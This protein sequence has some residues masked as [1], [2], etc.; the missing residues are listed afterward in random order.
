VFTEHF[1]TG[2]DA[3]LVAELTRH[4]DAVPNGRQVMFKLTLPD[5]SDLYSALLGGPRS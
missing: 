4:L 1:K 5:V 2:A 3:I